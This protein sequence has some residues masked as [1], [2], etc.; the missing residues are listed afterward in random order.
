MKSPN[1]PPDVAAGTDD[2]HPP[3]TCSV[4]TCKFKC[5]GCGRIKEYLEWWQPIC[6]ACGDVTM[7]KMEIRVKMPELHDREGNDG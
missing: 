7:E 1:R 2:H 3:T 6:R 4:E 5:P